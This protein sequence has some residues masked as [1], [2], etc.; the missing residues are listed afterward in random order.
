MFYP[1]YLGDVWETFTVFGF[2]LKHFSLAFALF[3]FEAVIIITGDIDIN[4]ELSKEVFPFIGTEKEKMDSLRQW[5]NHFFLL[6]QY[7]QTFFGA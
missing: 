1:L 6:K 3:C 5:E 7:V 2:I 4:Q